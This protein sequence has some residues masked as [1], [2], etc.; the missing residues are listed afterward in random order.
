MVFVGMPAEMGS[1]VR[2]APEEEPGETMVLTG[3]V[4]DRG[5]MPAEGVVV[6]AYHTDVTGMYPADAG[7]EGSRHTHG[8]LRGWALTDD[9]GRYT[10]RTIRPGAYPEGTEPEH[11]HLHVVEPGRCTYYIDDVVFEGDPNLT[12]GIRAR[13]SLRGGPGIT[14]PER[15]GTG[16]WRVVRDILLGENIPGYP[17]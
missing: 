14:V 6:Y 16:A 1:D 8:R 13:F 9:E 11:V 12:E 3:V 17:G 5:G 10:F 4:R 7:P 2:I 15:D